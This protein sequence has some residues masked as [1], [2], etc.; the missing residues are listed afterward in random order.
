MPKRLSI[1]KIIKNQKTGLPFV[2]GPHIN[3]IKKN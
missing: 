1:E 3:I 2:M